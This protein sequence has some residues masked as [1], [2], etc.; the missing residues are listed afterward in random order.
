MIKDRKIV[1][2]KKILQ[3]HAPKKGSPFLNC[4]SEPDAEK[5]KNGLILVDHLSVKKSSKIGHL[6]VK[7][8]VTI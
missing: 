6:Q 7:R 2:M 8:K 5:R 1:K 4:L 3:K